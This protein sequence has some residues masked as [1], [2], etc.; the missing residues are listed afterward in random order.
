MKSEKNKSQKQSH[1]ELREAQNKKRPAF[2]RQCA[3]KKMRVS[4]KWRYPSGIHSKLRERRGGHIPV[5]Q[6]GFRTPADVR[7]L[8]NSGLRMIMV[9]SP[10]ELAAVKAG[11]DGII[12]TASVGMR[13][14]MAIIAE[15]KK[16]GIE[17]LNLDAEKYAKSAEKKLA[18][19]KDRKA[20]VTS[21]K[22][23]SKQA[24]KEA[25]KEEPKEEISED[26]KKKQERKEMEKVLTSKE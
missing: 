15:A 8:H 11:E 18:Q 12:I 4:L 25:K 10:G 5:V 23:K 7:G 21:R 24:K 26:E 6:T 17:I 3:H 14:R 20:A 9:S 1:L 22:E 19:R 13:K 16:M 2:I